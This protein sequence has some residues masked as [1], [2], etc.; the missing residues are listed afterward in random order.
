MDD[1]PLTR[2]Y[3]NGRRAVIQGQGRFTKSGPSACDT[4]CSVKQA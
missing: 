3:A 4:A 2:M 1:S